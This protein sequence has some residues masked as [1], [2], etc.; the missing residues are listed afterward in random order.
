M[1]NKPDE[2][3]VTDYD[4]L[5]SLLGEADYSG[6][7]VGELIAVWYNC[8][9]IQEFDAAVSIQS[10]LKMSLDKYSHSRGNHEK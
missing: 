8:N 2:Y 10:S 3:E 9:T 7:T 4:I 5:G 1:T 6:M